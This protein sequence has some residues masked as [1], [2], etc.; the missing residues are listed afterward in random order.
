[1]P[2]YWQK[3]MNTFLK[4]WR[5]GGLTVF[6]YLDDIL[7]LGPSPESVRKALKVV[8]SDLDSSGLLLNMEK[9]VIEPVQ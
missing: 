7:L 4:K 9:S 6:I 3:L 1:M 5:Q 8:L 2:F